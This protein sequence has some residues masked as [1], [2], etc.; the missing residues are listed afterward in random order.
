MH[1]PPR[2]VI[3]DDDPIYLRVWEKVFRGIVECNYCLTND[4][5]TVE[6]VL[7]SEPVDLVISD[8][9]MNDRNGY[10]I[11]KLVYQYQPNAQLL[12]TTGYDCNV[13]HFDIC[14]PKF[15]LLYKPYHNITDIQRLISHL[16]KNDDNF[17][18]DLSEDSCSEKED[19]PNVTEWRL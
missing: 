6:A 12:L 4:F 17:F 16:L 13:K 3:I 5:E 11:A 2:V 19:A 14:S 7:A 15:H 18:Q 10:E 9:V 8:I 1:R